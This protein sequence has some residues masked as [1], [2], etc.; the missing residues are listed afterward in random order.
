MKL[1][2][3]LAAM[4]LLSFLCSF[5]EKETIITGKVVG[6]ADKLIYSNPYQGTCHPGFRDTINID[7]KGNI[8][9]KEAK[10]PSEIVLGE[11]I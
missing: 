4:L 2:S 9:Q 5:T 7:E 1:Y 6:N 10:H 11:E 8:L 3:S